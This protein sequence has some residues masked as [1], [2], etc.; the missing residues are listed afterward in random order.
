MNVLTLWSLDAEPEIVIVAFLWDPFPIVCLLLHMNRLLFIITCVLLHHNLL[1]MLLL[2]FGV[3][4]ML[5]GLVH[6]VELH[7]IVIVGTIVIHI[8]ILVVWALTHYLLS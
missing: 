8:E 4:A 7:L 5:H 1:L 6:K 2:L 3:L